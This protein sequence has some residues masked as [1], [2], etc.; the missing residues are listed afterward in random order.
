MFVENIPTDVWTEAMIT[1]WL[2]GR[3]PAVTLKQLGMEGGVRALELSPDLN[4]LS[5]VYSSISR[6]MFFSLATSPLG[7][8]LSG[9]LSGLNGIM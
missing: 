6:G 9:V 7:K 2:E 1:E 5:A 4:S 3:R 8:K